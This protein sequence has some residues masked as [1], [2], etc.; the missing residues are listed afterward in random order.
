[1]ADVNVRPADLKTADVLL[2]HGKGFIST[3]IRL[4][5]GT[6]VSHAG[7]CFAPDFNVVE[8][9]G[10]KDG[11]VVRRPLATSVGGA[12]YVLVFRHKTAPVGSGLVEEVVR[13]YVGEPYAY[14]Q[15]VMLA[16]LSITRRAKAT[17]A[18]AMLIRKAADWAAA[19]LLGW[20]RDG[21]K[22]LIC[23]EL[24]YRGYDEALPEPTDVYSIE[25]RRPSAVPSFAAVSRSAEPGSVLDFLL[26]PAGRAVAPAGVAFAPPPQPPAVT[27]AEVEEVARAYVEEARGAASDASAFG[28]V[29]MGEEVRRSVERFAVAWSAAREPAAA[30]FSPAVAL[31]VLDQAVP[32]FVTPGDLYMSPT[33]YRVGRLEL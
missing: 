5:D 30:E 3:A 1:M 9:I 17:P 22:A 19:R 4:I 32:D 7:A 21:K 2:Y 28:A 11:G 24:V 12:E 26:G 10:G 13:S 14:E 18:L 25:L 6:E 23:S 27:D 20:A 8:A 29:V 15:I 16:F 31:G 33:L